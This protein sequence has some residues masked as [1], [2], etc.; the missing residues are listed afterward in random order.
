MRE[1]GAAESIL[2]GGVGVFAGPAE[3][4][5]EEA[6]STAPAVHKPFKLQS[7][8]GPQVCEAAPPRRRPEGGGAFADVKAVICEPPAEGAVTAR[9]VKKTLRMRGSAL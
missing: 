2:G 8:K 5:Q 9:L 4:R 1:A 3:K 6:A 7:A